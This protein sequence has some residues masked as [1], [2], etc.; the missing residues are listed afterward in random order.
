MS[1]ITAEERE[2]RR[3]AVDNARHSTEMEGGRSSENMR[4]AQEAYVRGEIDLDDLIEQAQ[5]SYIPTRTLFLPVAPVQAYL[6]C[7][8]AD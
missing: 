3:R 4:E 5:H 7:E 8:T 6:A 1:R 2:R